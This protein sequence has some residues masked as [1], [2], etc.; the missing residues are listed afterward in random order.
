M[1]SSDFEEENYAH[2]DMDF[3][4]GKSSSRTMHLREK[5]RKR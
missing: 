4:H 2:G 1:D 3:S 5:P